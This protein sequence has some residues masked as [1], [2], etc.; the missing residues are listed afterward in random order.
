MYNAAASS[1]DKKIRDQLEA[2]PNN[3]DPFGAYDVAFK[4]FKD[5]LKYHH[6]SD[7]IINTMPKYIN[8]IYMNLH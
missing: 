6:F 3:M 7:S 1:L 8:M 5:R 2:D 4:L